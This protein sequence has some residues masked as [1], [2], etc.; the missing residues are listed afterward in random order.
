MRRL[1]VGVV[2]LGVG[3][4]HIDGFD[5]DERC[6][7][8]AVCDLDAE[9]LESARRERPNLATTQ[10][11][12]DFVRDA[13]ID[14]VSIAS[15]DDA[16]F[17]QTVAA[18]EAGKH[19][20]VEK[21]VCRTA[22]EV[23]SLSR[24]LDDHP[25]LV[26]GSNLVLRAAPLYR[27]AREQAS[28]GA[29]GTLYAF[30]G[31]YLY[32]RLHKITDGWRGDIADY[33][34]ML[35]GGDPSRRPHAVDNRRA[36]DARYRRWKPDRD[37]RH[38]VPLRRLRGGDVRDAFRLG[39]TDHGELRFGARPPARRSRLRDGSDADPRRRR[40]AHSSQSRA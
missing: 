6:E 34:V 18:L 3:A 17:E 25:G 36:P 4:R 35:G 26:L 27:F 23:R 33:S 37:G 12:D 5:A 19:V 13:D 16:H 21:P 28:A 10:R 9:R 1:R 32:G 8:A 7:V 29:F 2:G 11:F 38:Q 15:Y 30:D 24:A 20:F 14:I 31:D 22:D 40:A 39:R